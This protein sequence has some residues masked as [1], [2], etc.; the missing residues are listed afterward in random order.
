MFSREF[1]WYLVLWVVL[2]AI[3]FIG[4][5]VERANACVGGGAHLERHVSD[6]DT[7]RISCATTPSS[8]WIRITT[9]FYGE[10]RTFACGLLRRKPRLR[11]IGGPTRT[12]CIRPT[13][14]PRP[15][16]RRRRR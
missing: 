6:I 4:L 9:G 2:F 11:F 15:K 14:R 10:M 5:G 8:Q 7:M 1:K 3:L 13:D 12:Q 16:R